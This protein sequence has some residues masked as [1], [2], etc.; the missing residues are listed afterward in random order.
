VSGRGP[1][2]EMHRVQSVASSFD[3]QLW[4]ELE[5]QARRRR[6]NDSSVGPS[7]FARQLATQG[8]PT[9]FGQPGLPTSGQP[10]QQ[11]P[12]LF[13]QP[14]R[15]V[16]L[17]PRRPSAFGQATP[18]A[19]SGNMTSPFAAAAN[20]KRAVAAQQ[21]L[22]SQAADAHADQ[23]PAPQEFQ[24]PSRKVGALPQQ[25]SSVSA[26]SSLQS[27]Q[28]GHSGLLVMD[29]PESRESP[30]THQGSSAAG[31]ATLDS[32]KPEAA[33]IAPAQ[34]NKPQEAPEKPLQEAMIIDELAVLNKR[35]K[36]RP[37]QHH[38]L[39]EMMAALDAKDTTLHNS[40][41]G[42]EL[43]KQEH[44]G[45]L[46]KISTDPARVLAKAVSEG[47]TGGE[48]A[49]STFLDVKSISQSVPE[50]PPQASTSGMCTAPA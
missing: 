16:A 20:S 38:R 34:S 35:P 48:L 11:M 7:P 8:T 4:E 42:S 6:S 36:R 21:A 15:P 17:M 39:A 43:S 27:L 9:L 22:L 5:A 49:L 33:G 30:I 10:G 44:D 40:S 24:R 47:C 26:L 29:V 37:V 3:E 23:R 50:L 32:A 1:S 46:S 41:G 13:G 14:G 31:L 25:P 45:L 19:M 28:N 18:P 12:T 2:L